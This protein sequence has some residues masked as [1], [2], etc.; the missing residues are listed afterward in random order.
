MLSNRPLPFAG[1]VLA[2]IAGAAML[3]AGSSVWLALGVVAL[4]LGS[5]WLAIPEPEI[6]KAQIPTVVAQGGARVQVVS[7]EFGG[8]RGPAMTYSPVNVWDT[9]LSAGQTLDLTLKDGY[10]TLF[11][12]L[13]GSVRVNGAQAVVSPA[14]VVLDREGTEAKLEALSGDATVLILNGEPLNEPVVGYGP[15]VMNTRDEIMQAMQDFQ[16]G[17]FIRTKAA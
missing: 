12:V 11:A 13:K 6:V 9:Q 14:L 2:L 3:V 1:I 17:R 15:F 10:T 4:W 7:G 16:Q 8:E 5:L